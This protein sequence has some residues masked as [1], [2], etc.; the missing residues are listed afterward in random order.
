MYESKLCY[1]NTP[2]SVSFQP[3]KLSSHT[4][5]FPRLPAS[6]YISVREGGNESGREEKGEERKGK[7]KG[8]NRRRREREGKERRQER[9]R[10]KEGTLDSI[11]LWIS[12][13]FRSKRRNSEPL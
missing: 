7:E 10:N 8:Y 4:G 9:T 3:E 1:L 5:I 2:C 6:I 12:K 11:T 13:L